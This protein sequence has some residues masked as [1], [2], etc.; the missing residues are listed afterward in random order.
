MV[1]RSLRLGDAKK[2]LVPD[3]GLTLPAPLLAA[4]KSVS[5]CRSKGSQVICW[6]KALLTGER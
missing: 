3:H 2:L 5:E 4:I 6:H 1:G